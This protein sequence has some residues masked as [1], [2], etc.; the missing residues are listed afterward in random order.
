MFYPAL[1]ISV[2]IGLR[3]A[4]AAWDIDS[5]PTPGPPACLLSPL[6]VACCLV[7]LVARQKQEYTPGP[8]V[9]E[10]KLLQQPGDHIL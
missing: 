8:K 3:T 1:S 10:T 9:M 4:L 2:E 5:R 6:L 7:L